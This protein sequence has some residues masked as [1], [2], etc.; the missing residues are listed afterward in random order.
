MKSQLLS[1]VLVVLWV[2]C[3]AS[4]SNFV[5][6]HPIPSL[7]WPAPNSLYSPTSQSLDTCPF[8]ACNILLLLVYLEKVYLS[9]SSRVFPDLSPSSLLTHPPRQSHASVTVLTSARRPWT[10]WGQALPFVHAAQSWMRQA[11]KKWMN[12]WRSEGLNEWIY[13]TEKGLQ[14]SSQDSGGVYPLRYLLCLNTK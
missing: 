12:K 9:L 4:F 5:S 11:I 2:L 13:S 14:I 10:P 3:V 1:Q 6:F 8:S 7:Y